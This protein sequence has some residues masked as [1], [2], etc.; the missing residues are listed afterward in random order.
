METEIAQESNVS[1]MPSDNTFQHAAKIAIAEDKPILL[2]YWKLS[3]AKESFIG[4]KEDDEKLLVKN[5]EEYTS[6]VAK[7]FECDNEYLIV[8][9]NS[10]YLVDKDL[11][12][13]RIS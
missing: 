13:K 12:T 10:I 1:R 5:A 3:L 11:P 9:E 8:T 2:D 4:V 7:I 6:P